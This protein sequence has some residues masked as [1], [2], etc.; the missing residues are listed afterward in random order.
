MKKMNDELSKDRDEYK[1]ALEPYK[2]FNSNPE[3][4]K[5]YQKKAA[6][7]FWEEE[8][9]DWTLEDVED[10]YMY[11]D[12]DQGENSSFNLYCKDKG[13][14]ADKLYRDAHTAERKYLSQCENVANKYLSEYGEK[15]MTNQFGYKS[16]VSKVVSDMLLELANDNMSPEGYYINF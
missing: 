4:V 12:G 11:D 8:G 15:P 13:L 16:T 3:L 9:Q 7:K 10:W 6:R 2:E 1:K 5:A 14:D